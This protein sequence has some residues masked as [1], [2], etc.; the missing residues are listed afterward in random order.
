MRMRVKEIGSNVYLSKV[1]CTLVQARK[2]NKQHHN[3]NTAIMDSGN[4]RQH[5]FNTTSFF[6]LG[7]T[8]QNINITGVSGTQRKQV[9]IGTAYCILHYHS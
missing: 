6:P 1:V 4:N 7:Y 8:M 2:Y 9:G 3:E 5:L